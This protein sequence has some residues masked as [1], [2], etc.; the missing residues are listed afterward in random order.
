MP[1]QVLLLSER[2]C[3]GVFEIQSSLR[4]DMEV[5]DLYVHVVLCYVYSSKSWI[6]C[7]SFW[8][9][10]TLQVDKRGHINNM[11]RQNRFV[12]KMHF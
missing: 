4:Y 3:V 5:I 2:V 8:D 11:Y 7:L 10:N 1:T 6:F 12:Y 9:F